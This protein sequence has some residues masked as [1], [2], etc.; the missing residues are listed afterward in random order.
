MSNTVRL[1]AK[2]VNISNGSNTNQVKLAL[3][4]KYNIE[5]S[6]IAGEFLYNSCFVNFPNEESCSNGVERLTSSCK[7]NLTDIGEVEFEVSRKQ[8]A[9]GV[10]ET[11]T[12]QVHSTPDCRN[13]LK[14]YKY[15]CKFSHPP[16]DDEIDSII[17]DATVK[18][19][20]KIENI[21]GS[22]SSKY[23]VILEL[24]DSTDNLD[25]IERS[26][27][28]ITATEGILD[29]AQCQLNEFKKACDFISYDRLGM[30][31][32]RRESN[33]L[34]S[35]LPFYGFRS[36]VVEAVRLYNVVIIIG[37]TGSGK[38]T[39]VSFIYCFMTISDAVFLFLLDCSISS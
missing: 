9:G 7:L 37:E 36:Q 28:D 10:K 12:R 14:C 31:Q 25:E 39:Q 6:S 32:L 11:P 17:F 26:Q 19:E 23:P 2:N 15:D 1:K 3:E 24:Q 20:A 5:I 35:G 21:F 18:Q 38:S 22:I 33:R 30:M 34:Q 29:I 13:G 27:E 16:C 4:E 8:K